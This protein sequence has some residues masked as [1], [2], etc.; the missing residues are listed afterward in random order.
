MFN[1]LKNIASS[2]IGWISDKISAVWDKIKA[3]KDAIASL[4]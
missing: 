1:G 4:W 2:T 3:A